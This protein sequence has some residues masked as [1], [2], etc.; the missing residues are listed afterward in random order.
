MINYFVKEIINSIVLSVIQYDSDRI[1]INESYKCPLPFSSIIN[2]DG[3]FCVG[4]YIF[5]IYHDNISTCAAR[6]TY[7]EPLFDGGGW[8]NLVPQIVIGN[9][10]IWT[11]EYGTL[12]ICTTEEKHFQEMT[13]TDFKGLEIEDFQEIKHFNDIILR[14]VCECRKNSK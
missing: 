7:I 10:E 6:L 5:G 1:I 11:P 3:H 13:R 9:D 14:W 4:D 2:P 12:P 8:Y